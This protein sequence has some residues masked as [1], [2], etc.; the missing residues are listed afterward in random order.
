MSRQPDNRT[1]VA[2]TRVL[3]A[4]VAVAAATCS[5]GEPRRMK[6]AAPAVWADPAVIAGLDLDDLDRLREAGAVEVFVPAAHLDWA[7]GGLPTLTADPGLTAPRRLPATLVVE[8]T[9]PAGAPADAKAVVHRLA[10]ELRAVALAAERGGLIPVGFHFVPRMAPDQGSLAAYAAVLA[11]LRRELDPR[12]Y[13]SSNL[14]RRRLGDPEARELAGAVDFLVVLLFGQR[15]GE[16]DDVAAWDLETVA[17][18]ARALDALGAPFWARVTTLGSLTI[19]DPS[20]AP[21]ALVTGISLGR[22]AGNPALALS[23]SQVFA[24]GSRQITVFEADRP[25]KLGDHNLVRGQRVRALRP[26]PDDLLE[27]TRRLAG[28]ELKHLSGQ[29]YD[30]LPA[31]GDGMSLSLGTVAALLRGEEPPPGLVVEMRP[32]AGGGTQRFT[33]SVSNRGEQ[34]TGVALFD[35]N[36][37]ELTVRGGVVATVERGGFRR[38]ALE[39]GGREAANMQDLLGADGVRLFVPALDP[40][41]TVTSGPIAVRATGQGIPEIVAGGRFI[42]ATGNAY[43]L[44]RVTLRR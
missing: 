43:E 12:L 31:A 24:G 2:G 40:G 17:A 13:L 33:V 28:L 8:G 22:L 14:D 27:L 20:G 1:R 15:P 11:A 4:L 29:I 25:T 5:G 23:R 18:R 10:D 16:T 32:L 38:Y 42:V 21:V 30:R 35:N 36:F 6:P 44:P 3:V 19:L 39:R 9:W 37:V 26:D 34:C 7:G 41:E